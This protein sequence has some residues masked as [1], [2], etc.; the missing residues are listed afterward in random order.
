MALANR[1][2]RT[3][4][5]QTAKWRVHGIFAFTT[6]GATVTVNVP[7]SSVEFAVAFPIGTPAS[8]EI[9]SVNNTVVGTVGDDTAKI[10]GTNGNTGLVITR[11]GASKTTGLKFC[12]ATLGRA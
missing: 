1:K 5:G 12:L 10:N 9:L 4:T 11:T 6:T 2:T 7:L 3:G 8:D